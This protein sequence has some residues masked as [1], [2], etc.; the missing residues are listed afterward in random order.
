MNLIPVNID[1]IRIGQPLPFH[2]V[3]KD[4]VLLARKSFVIASRADLLVISQRGGGLF[5]DGVDGEALHRAYVD[6][7]QVLMRA[8]KSIG[9]IAGSKLDAAAAIKRTALENDQLDWLDLQVQAHH[10]MR[11]PQSPAFFDRLD[12]LHQI[13]GNEMARGP[14]GCLF[15]LI[16]LAASELKM[17]SA[18]HSMLVCVMCALASRDV[19]NWP[20][21]TE[22][23]LRKVTLTM[24]LSISEL[25]DKLASQ[26]G[27]LDDS[28]RAQIAAHSNRS[29]QLLQNI[30]V[31]D[32]VWL[33]AVRAHH[34]PLPGPLQPKAP[35]HRIARL[36]ERADMFAARLSPRLVRPAVSPAVAM[37]ACYFDEN[38][39]VDEAGAALI[40]AIG[41]YPPGTFVRLAT[42]EI[43][44]VVRRGSNTS[45]PRVAVVINRTGIPTVEPTVRDT[46][47][48]E[49]RVVASVAHREIKVQI[50]LDRMLALTHSQP[51]DRPW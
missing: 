27:D 17:Y 42:N 40:K 9:E 28:Q 10:L 51:T 23:L 7:L 2:L 47:L 35:E 13:L 19:L 49:Y 48:K 1:S 3:D 21:A 26:G 4:G 22:V 8:E 6:Q 33:E 29:A 16:Y 43:A 44:I 50:K 34:T 45:T 11:D 41:I 15:A 14:D 46:A 5:I 38:K 20:E 36:V 37:Q 12:N 32:P 31:T 18:T 39:Q 24:N 25:Q 30:G